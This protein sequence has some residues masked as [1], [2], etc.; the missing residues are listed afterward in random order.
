MTRHPMR[1]RIR[2]AVR[3]LA[4]STGLS[5]LV[6][7][8]ISASLPAGLLPAWLPTAA[9]KPAD[10]ETL[11][12]PRFVS[13]TVMPNGQ[14]GLIFTNVPGSSS[15][16]RFVRYTDE[17]VLAQSIQLSTAEGWYPQL[18]VLGTTLVAAYADTR[19]PNVGKLILRTSTDN[20]ATWSAESNPFGSETFGTTTFAPRLVASRS[21]TTLYLFS[22]VNGSRP[23]YRYT[24]DLSTWT[25]AVDAGDT[26]MR[27]AG[28]NNCGS[29]GQ[30]CYR[31][32]AFGFMET[33]TAGSWVYITK[34]D[35]G[36][37]QSGRGTQVG[38]LG[39]SWSAQ[40]DHGGSGGLSGGGDST[41]TT[42]LDRS[43]NVYFIRGTGYGDNVY[44]KQSSDG[45]ATWGPLSNAYA[46]TV[47][48][49]LGAAPVGLY[50]PSYTYG[51]YVWFAGFG[52]AE[53]TTRV[54]PLWSASLPYAQSGTVRLFGS[55]GGDI[56]PGSAYPF[57]YGDAQSQLGAGGYQRQQLD[58]ALPGRLLPLSFIRTYNSADENRA[59]ALGPGWRHSFEW[60][61]SD[62]GATVILQRGDGARDRYTR[63]QDGSY[64]RPP[65]VFDTLVKNSDGSFTLTTPGQVQYEFA[66]AQ[67]G[68]Y[69]ATVLA[70]SPLA[71]WR[72]GE[73]SGTTAADSGPNNHAGT[74]A[75]AVTLGQPGAPHD[76]N[77]AAKLDGATGTYVSTTASA[78]N[79]GTAFTLEAWVKP[80]TLGVANVVISRGGGSGSNLQYLIDIESGVPYV[81]VGNGSTVVSAAG[82]VISA[83]AWTHLAATYDGTKAN[84]YVNGGLASF[85][86]LSSPLLSSSSNTR[87]GSYS[88]GTGYSFAGVLDEVAVWSSALSPERIAAHYG[89]AADRTG[90]LVRIH[91]PAGNQIALTYGHGDLASITD[92]VGRVVTLGYDGA[93]RL[94][95]L[96]D[97][98]GRTVWYGYDGAGRL[99]A[100]SQPLPSAPSGAYRSAVIA[101]T[102][103]SYWKLDETSGSTATDERGV[104]NGSTVGA[105]TLNSAG[106]DGTA[107]A[108][109][110][111]TGSVD[112]GGASALN[113]TGALSLEAWVRPT[114]LGNVNVVISRGGGANSNLQYLLDIEAGVPSFYVG[115]GTGFFMATGTPLATG[116]WAHVVGAYDGT[117]AQIYVNG[118]AGTPTTLAAPLMS[119]S[120]HPRAAAYADGSGYA[121]GGTIDEPAIYSYALSPSRVQAHFNTGTKTAL[122]WQYAYDGSSRHI[123][124]VTDPDGRVVVTNTYD[125]VGRL[126][127]QKDGLNK[128]TTLTYG[129]STTTMTDPRA[130][131]TVT[132]YDSRSRLIS[133]QDVVGANTYTASF[134]YDDC[135]DRSSSTDRNGNRTD[136]TY[137]T[138]CKG[139]LLTLQEP[140]LNPQTPR[141]TTAWTYDAK[142]NLTLR[143]DAK[144][145]TTSWTYDATSNARLSETRQ[146]DAT[147]SAV[148]KW[149]YGDSANP[150]LPTRV[151]APRG[152]TT[153]T[154]DNTYSTV[155]A[156]D[157]SGNLTS[158][159]DADGS[160]TTYGYDSIGRRT[161]MVDPDGNATG[162][163]PAEH[164][165]TTAYDRLDRVTSETDPLANSSSQA[166]DGA[167]HKTTA[168]DKNGNIIT[169]SY[170]EAGR[171]STVKQ[172]PDPVGAPST[173]Y[174]TAISRDDNGNATSVTQANGVVTDYSY[175]DLNRLQGMTTHP[176]TGTTLV[177]AYT[178]D[179]NGNVTGRHTAD[180]VD[181]TYTFDSLSRLTQIA[182]T[183]L[184]TISYAYDELSRRTSMTDGSGTTTYSYDRMG[185]LTQAA[186]PNGTT[187]YAYDPDS[188]RTSLTYPGPVA[189]SYV[190]SNA[191]RLSSLTDWGSRSSSFTYTPAGLAK[192]VTLPNSMVT[193]YTYDRAQRLTNLT[194]IV[195]STTIT[196]HAYT[197]DAEGN[198]TALSEFISGITTGASDSFGFTYDGLERLTAVTTTNAESFTLDAASNITARTGPAK[199][200]TIDGSN[201][202]TSDG[203]STLTWSAADR[204]TGRGADTFGFDPLDRLTSSTVAGTARTYAYNGDGLLQSRT[205]GGS[206]VTLVWDPTSSPSRLL[207]SGSDKIV[208]GL[209]PLYA[210][211]GTTVTTYA[212]DG[213]KSIRAELNGTS[214]TSSWRYR[215]YGETAQNS[216]AAAPSILGYAG[217]LLDPSGLYYMRARWYDATNARFVSRDRL[218]GSAINPGTLNAFAYAGGNPETLFDPS[219]YA[220]TGLAPEGCGTTCR[221]QDSSEKRMFS[222]NDVYC[223]TQPVWQP[224]SNDDQDDP[225]VIC[226]PVSGT[227]SLFARKNKSASTFAA[228]GAPTAINDRLQKILNYIFKGATNPSRTGDGSTM[229]AI[230]TELAS[231]E[232][233]FGKWHSG[234]GTK[235]V[236]MLEEWLESSPVADGSD[237]SLAKQYLQDMK[238]ALSGR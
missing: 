132:S 21:G 104:S 109:D 138:G 153:G 54:V 173:V 69:S 7:S 16:I 157:S 13:A 154:P 223:S 19:S 29:A 32:H 236:R 49:Y 125:A 78:L 50:V 220:L 97:P 171:L 42:F 40:V 219:G 84:L 65:G 38:T 215:A 33:A 160:K 64:S 231:G 95:Q 142:N 27:A 213:Q 148:T 76:N 188:N 20:G 174:T 15:E 74:Y 116:A 207:V 136:Y 180:G 22:A 195:G 79:L 75:G 168:T 119:T 224:T 61:V 100:V 135:G 143:T 53:N 158:S 30:E 62:L 51:E 199:T 178:L 217:Q 145:F 201:R 25:S 1:R 44:L 150:G 31:A 165:W 111:L 124:S 91:E 202:P 139:N 164:I 226:L 203:T 82:P 197:L 2:R 169:Y 115:K 28:A 34:S 59:G 229:A 191:G 110:G 41:A 186:Q 12:S 23:T 156:Y 26:S 130:H 233:T 208:Y 230:R 105:V 94:T 128:Q 118:L 45:G 184:A 183:G 140:Q 60:S 102:P 112:L 6:L 73:S 11:A 52:G 77:T 129:S 205:T 17:H 5:L 120:Y 35:S 152:N 90:R 107:F 161:S 218:D 86:T 192:T 126:A 48:N 68:P 176:A 37:G 198:R 3:R 99:S 190:Y 204:L 55:A 131:N 209:G 4:R 96:R 10:A 87:L 46:S 63:N 117:T 227:C 24:T 177:T 147:T 232:S 8:V 39:G 85:A 151:V 72:L 175:D 89:A 214:V 80:S 179:G 187:A 182:A 172:K 103:V 193:T 67:S 98:S 81:W 88:N 235:L 162:G 108:F 159:T 14:V 137:D 57:N 36:F 106:I 155:L 114:S 170:D 210:L 133:A 146:I 234:E 212:R 194:N 123:T 122:S 144:G 222:C 101:D 121:L 238:D 134:T 196:S 92:T 141:F 70:D 58:L 225:A 166:Y 181:T 221:R 149:I 93:H 83:G 216:G 211:S 163:V 113:L 56:D 47:A 200:F 43:G 189:V 237:V 18:A 206:T 71:Y 127:T 167:G 9:P 228:P 66:G 185:R